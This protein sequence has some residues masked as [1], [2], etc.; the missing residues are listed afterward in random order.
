MFKTLVCLAVFQMFAGVYNMTPKSRI[1]P[2]GYR[3]TVSRP[4]LAWLCFFLALLCS[5][6]AFLVH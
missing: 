5:L 3:I 1:H 2:N 6:G 4:N